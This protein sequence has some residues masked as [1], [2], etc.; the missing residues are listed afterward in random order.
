MHTEK[1]RPKETLEELVRRTYTVRGPD[2]NEDPQRLA[3]AM[4]AVREANPGGESS[5]EIKLPKIHHL[6]RLSIF[7]DNLRE[8]ERALTMGLGR[9]LRNERLMALS[10]IDPLRVATEELGICC[11]PTIAVLF[12][13]R[14]A[15]LVSFDSKSYEALRDRP[16]GPDEHS[17]VRWVPKRNVPF[18][19]SEDLQ[20]GA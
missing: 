1:R 17:E 7:V 4:Q 9:V 6:P 16:W 14:Y 5:R 10:F 13:R 8:A 19:P 11:T 2:G 18:G 12:R 20:G 3:K 15:K